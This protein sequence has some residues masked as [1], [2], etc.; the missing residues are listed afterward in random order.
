MLPELNDLATRCQASGVDVKLIYI[1]EAHASDEWPIGNKFR[2]DI[3]TFSQTHTIESRIKAAHQLQQDFK[4]TMPIFVDN[5]V[6]NE[7]EQY[8]HPWP[9]RWYLIEDGICTFVGKTQDALFD[10]D[11]L[12]QK[13]EKFLLS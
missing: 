13:L 11:L 3:L 1:A 2:T 5:P 4:L 10:I 9:L 12:K 8:F 6:G 7:F